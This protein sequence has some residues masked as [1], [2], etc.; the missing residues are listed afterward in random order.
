MTYALGNGTLLGA[1]TNLLPT[2][3]VNDMGA[4][5]T[6][7]Q[8]DAWCDAM[9]AKHG[10]GNG[11]GP[12]LA[13]E[14]QRLAL[15]PT[16][17]VADARNTRNATA[18]RSEG[19]KRGHAGTTLSDVAWLGSWGKYEAAVRRWEA[20]TRPAPPPTIRRD[21]RDWLSPS[22]VEWMQGYPAGWIDG[23]ADPAALKALG[24]AVV[25]QQAAL[26][27]DLLQPSGITTG[28]ARVSA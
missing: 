21:D 28:E 20:F 7:E 22:F 27:L 25:T 23:M 14:A 19:A 1:V 15:L 26:A 10:N 4:N 16:P 12:S 24:N 5:K 9:K 8:W 2:P 18:G 6:P 13:I 17:T 3:V 11:H